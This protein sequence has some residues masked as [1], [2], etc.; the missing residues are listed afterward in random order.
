[1]TENFD[2][3]EKSF[4]FGFSYFLAVELLRTAVRFLGVGFWPLSA[5]PPR[6]L[7]PLNRCA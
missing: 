5:S 6:A 4:I 1:M 7:R 3:K 2:G